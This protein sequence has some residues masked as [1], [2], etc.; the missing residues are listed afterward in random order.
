LS[1]KQR[2]FANEI[3]NEAKIVSFVV[4]VW[5]EESTSEKR[6]AVWRGHITPISSGLRHYFTNIN[7]IPVFIATHLKIQP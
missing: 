7:E 4:R 5:R 6:D 3:M 1:K 2:M